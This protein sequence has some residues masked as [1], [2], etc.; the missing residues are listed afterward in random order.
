MSLRRV[1][2][3]LENLGYAP[4][5]VI[6]GPETGAGAAASREPSRR[7]EEKF[8]PAIPE[9]AKTS[10]EEI[11]K[12]QTPP[13]R[14]FPRLGVYF[15]YMDKQGIRKTE[16]VRGAAK[17]YAAEYLSLIRPVFKRL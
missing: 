16:E 9:V 1:D 3:Y 5:L 15:G 13:Y 4:V 2:E 7:I 10:L 17:V 8:L 6:V 14:F 11:R 12:E